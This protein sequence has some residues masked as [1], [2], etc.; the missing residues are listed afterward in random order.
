MNFFQQQ[1][2]ARNKSLL[3]II[4]F[5]LSIVI[6]IAIIDL[7]IIVS[8]NDPTIINN[9]DL[10]NLGIFIVIITGS[11]AKYIQ[12]RHGGKSIVDMLKAMPIYRDNKQTKIRQLIN[13]VDEISIASGVTC[14]NLYIMSEEAGINA[15]VSGYTPNDTVLVVTQGA[16]DN[17]SRDELQGVIAHE[18]SHIYNS[19]TKI[20]L[21]LLIVLA[22]LVSLS[23]MGEVM[24]RSKNDRKGQVALIGLIFVAFGAIGLFFGCMLK[25]AISRQRESLADASSVQFTRNPEGLVTA[26][27]KIQQQGEQTFLKNEHAEQISHMCFSKAQ[28]SAFAGLFATHPPIESRIAALDPDN[29]FQAKAN[30]PKTTPNNIINNIGNPNSDSF[31]TAA[32]MLQN[33]PDKLTSMLEN[34]ASAQAIIYAILAIQDED[35]DINLLETPDAIKQL[36]IQNLAITQL[37][38]PAYRLAILELAIPTLKLL[39]TNQRDILIK[40]IYTLI[41]ADNKLSLFEAA[42]Y[43]I[44]NQRLQADAYMDNQ[45]KYFSWLRLKTEVC[46]IM[47]YLASESSTDPN[48][49]QQAFMAGLQKIQP[50]MQINLTDIKLDMFQLIRDLKKLRLMSPNLKQLF[51]NACL[52]CINYDGEI[53]YNET[54]LLRAICASLDCPMP[55]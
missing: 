11:I 26:L 1:D 35:I 2:R 44:L 40:N 31:I 5:I 14:P 55:I 9:L 25:A 53:R 15:F 47:A 3:L 22:G 46:H 39:N 7:A 4:G 17:L 43:T 51:L 21:R 42:E 50:N 19:D 13:I 10:I 33:M 34:I 37:K 52:S 18:Y 27:L 12:L 6:I 41:T 16:L 30:K 23:Q 32:A 54:E 49:Q 28:K 29:I 48:I 36:I 20:N 38:D 45:S 24:L 8:Q